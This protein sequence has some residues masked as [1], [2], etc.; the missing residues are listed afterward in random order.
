M[1]AAEEYAEHASV[2]LSKTAHKITV[3]HGCVLHA[4]VVLEAVTGPISIGRYCVLEDQCTVENKLPPGPDGKPRTM[5]IGDYCVF[6]PRSEVMAESVGNGCTLEAVAVVGAGSK[7]AE[8]CTVMASCKVPPFAEL[9]QGTVV[10][11]PDSDWRQTTRD[12]LM[13]ETKAKTMSR[14][15]RQHM[16]CRSI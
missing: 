8:G 7:L 16:R 1:A 9:P 5:V 10:Y 11:G 15:M 6:G 12:P 13:E 3:G 4:D 14:F 2:R